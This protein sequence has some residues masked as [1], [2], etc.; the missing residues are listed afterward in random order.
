MPGRVSVKSVSYTLVS[1]PFRANR[2]SRKPLLDSVPMARQTYPLEALRKLRDERAEAH[3]QGLAAQIARSQAAEAKLRERERV[4]REHAERTAESVRIERQRL[5]DGGASGADLLRVSEFDKAARAQAELLERAEGE[6]RQ[7]LARET[8]EEEKLRQQLS[9]REA[10]AK[11][12]RNH[13]AG[14]HEYH[15][16]LVQKSDEEAAL[17]QWNARRR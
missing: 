4:R 13:E 2:T 11:L 5:V 15:A 3:A 10:E 16:D 8:V 7:A 14:F 12:V 17:E 1:V 9:E 6:A